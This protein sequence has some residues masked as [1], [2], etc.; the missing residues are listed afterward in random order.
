MLKE[1]GV[2]HIRDYQKKKPKA[3]T[4][5]PYLLV[6]IDEFAEMK[7][8]APDFM[9]KV[10]NIARTGRTLGVHLIL[11]TQR[12]A[13]VITGQLNSN[14]KFRLCLRVET[15]EDSNDMLGRKDA[16]MI[17]SNLPGRAFF[18]VGSDVFE[19]FQVARAAIPF[20]PPEEQ[21]RLE[22]PVAMLMDEHWKPSPLSPE[23]YALRLK[24][25]KPSD[26][27]VILP[28]DYDIISAQ[29]AAAAKRTVI[30][31]THKPWLDPMEARY[32]LPHFLND[33]SFDP[34][35][36]IWPD[37][38]SFG[39]GRAPVAL[40][41]DVV[42][43]LQ[44]PFYLDL[45]QHGSYCISGLAVSGKTTVLR[46]MLT[47][48]ALTHS[49]RQLRFA[50]FDLSNTLKPFAKLP[51]PTTYLAMSQQNEMRQAIKD[52]YDELQNRRQLFA[53]KGV[54]DLTSYWQ[55]TPE[56][57][58]LP[59]I[60]VAFEN[61][62]SVKHNPPFE[63]EQLK[64]FIREGGAYGL[65]VAIT[66]DRAN[67]FEY[68]RLADQFFQFALRQQREDVTFN[69]P[70]NMVGSWEGKPGRG[71]IKGGHNRPPVE[72]HF[73]LACEDAPENQSKAI[74]ELLSQMAQAV[75]QHPQLAA[76][77]PALVAQAVPTALPENKSDSAFETKASTTNGVPA[78]RDENYW[79]GLFST[80]EE[81][82][83]EEMQGIGDRGI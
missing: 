30:H 58:P 59:A 36:M 33:K 16:A 60:F 39:Y 56:S 66:T 74:E 13:G 48:L 14:T 51:H 25:A 80:D 6:I 53:D 77:K 32:Y 73:F 20:A 9:D 64:A 10:I 22:Q 17:A 54:L 42:E 3:R 50:I 45:E 68:G 40:L 69:I 52:L 12:P 44:T 11:A 62:V 34:D 49:P 61:F 38:S 29:C 63:M 31:N 70:K 8:Q 37:T 67:D 57:E 79:D 4:P 2:T 26:G 41:D 15:P 46:T 23:K 83:E 43:Q 7:E 21:S 5:L 75:S 76:S 27:E 1:E 65:H 81:D 55:A 19:Q 82:E 24:A 18:K 72:V 47:A 71:F 28:L 35:K 78:A